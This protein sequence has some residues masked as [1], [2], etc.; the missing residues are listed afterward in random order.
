MNNKFIVSNWT[1][2]YK[3]LAVWFPILASGAYVMVNDYLATGNIPNE[4]LPVIV[5]LSGVLGWIK[6]QKSIRK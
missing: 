1:Q 4:Y 5:G 3:S 2:V 6:S